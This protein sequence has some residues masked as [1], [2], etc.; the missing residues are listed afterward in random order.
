VIAWHALL[1]FTMYIDRKTR[2]VNHLGH[3]IVIKPKS[4]PGTIKPGT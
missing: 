3:H 2:F 4:K 1:T